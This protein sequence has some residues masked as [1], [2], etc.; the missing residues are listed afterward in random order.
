MALTPATIRDAQ[1]RLRLDSPWALGFDADDGKKY[2]KVVI[3]PETGRKNK[4][5]YGAKGYKIAP[6]TDK[7]DRYCARSFGDMKSHGKDCSGP[8]RNTPLCLSRAK[9][10]CSGKTSRRDGALTPGKVLG[11]IAL[12]APEGAQ[13]KPCGESHIP[14]NHKCSKNQGLFTPRT[15]R[16][17]A[18]IALVAGTIAGGV[19]IARKWNAKDDH[20]LKESLQ[21]GKTWDV[22][23]QKRIEDSLDPEVAELRAEREARRERFC[24]RT[25]SG[26]TLAERIDA[27][28]SCARQVGEQS[29][30][31]QLFI[32]P[33]GNRI[34]KVP[35]GNSQI[36]ITSQ[37][38]R[39][40][41][42]NEFT[43]LE[44]AKK[45]GVE[46]PSPISIHPKTGVLQ[47]QYIPNSTTLRAY[48]KANN[49]PVFQRTLAHSLLNETRRMH[50]I[51]L[52]HN[53][54]HPGNILVTP[55]RKLFLID[56]GLAQS[57]RYSDRVET[58]AS[59]KDEMSR[60]IKRALIINKIP[61]VQSEIENWLQVRHTPLLN[62]L[63]RGTIANKQLTGGIDSWYVDLRKALDYKVQ[64]PSST[65]RLTTVL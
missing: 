54:L 59:L 32:H 46:V 12:D 22:Y 49:S 36:G 14:K 29:A 2:T 61:A 47:M 37:E 9:W 38:A 60:V 8:D 21:A 25:D 57:L 53:D 45:A 20:D 42:R 35:T 41:S 44:L 39:D 51:G 63:D 58:L 50:R 26:K 34:F 17:A 56:F 31:G 55:N 11:L 13:G 24:G 30:Y 28:K 4:V 40:A 18:K 3:N 64:R 7:G 5:R 1:L 10:R 65:L 52:V 27:F 16:T 43:H 48:N 6:G 19:A 23:E 33:D 15:L 62:A